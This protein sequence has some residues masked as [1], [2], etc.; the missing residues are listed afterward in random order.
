MNTLAR[1]LIRKFKTYREFFQPLE[2]G[3]SFYAMNLLRNGKWE[4]ADLTIRE[5]DEAWDRANRM[6]MNRLIRIDAIIQK[7]K[8]K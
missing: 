7:G 1:K 6:G 3:D 5:F 4:Q 2:R 8:W